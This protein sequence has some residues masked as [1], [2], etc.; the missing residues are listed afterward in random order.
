MLAVGVT[1]HSERA[2]PSPRALTAAATGAAERG[3]LDA[4]VRPWRDQI[5]SQRSRSALFAVASFE[6][7]RY[8]YARAD[9]LY[10]RVMAQP[11]S[12]AL[13]RQAQLWR[14]ICDAH[15]FAQP[16]TRVVLWEWVYRS[17]Q[18]SASSAF[19]VIA[20]R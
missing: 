2:V 14:A 4:W 1:V 3:S 11:S 7:L 8:R 20:K 10:A 13:A 17:K 12:D 6:R 9:S 16:L 19:G 18:V 5:V 15:K